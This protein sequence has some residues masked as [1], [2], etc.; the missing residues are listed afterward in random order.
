M[1]KTHTLALVAMLS[2][3]ALG[4]CNNFLT[5][6]KL[7]NNPNKS[8]AATADQLF[9]G[10]QVA[11]MGQFE[12]YPMNLLP[13]WDQQIAGVNRQWRTLSNFGQGTD[14][15]TSD[16]LWNAFYGGGGLADIKRGIAAADAVGNQK[17]IGQFRVLEA[18]YMGTAADLWGDVPFDSAGNPFPTFDSQAAVYAH[19]QLL[20]DSAITDLGAGG[21]GAGVDFYFSGDFSK[22]IAVAHTLKA[23]YY[24]HTAELPNLAY[25][26]AILQLVISEAAQGVADPSGSLQTVHT[27]NTFEQNLFYQ[28][29]VGSRKGDVEPS[30]IHI[31]LAKQFNDQV[32][33]A[34]LYSRNSAGQY[35]GSS[36]GQSAGSLVSNFAIA[37]DY[38][39]PLVTYSENILLDAEAR[40]RRGDTGAGGAAAADLATER[41]TLGETG[42][43]T[44]PTGANA[45]LVAILDEKYL[46]NFLNPE[47]YFDYLRT[48]V[49]NVP[50]PV[51]HDSN[52]PYVPA[53]FQY[54]YTESTTNTANIPS[55]AGLYSNANWPKHAADPS[56][57]TCFGQAGRPENTAGTSLHH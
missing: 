37:P 9:I 49:P 23:R 43:P 14:N 28:F 12:P 40:Y 33:L 25:D 24:M 48:C 45:L 20:L 10:V 15:L 46:Q 41:A 29:L 26:D 17:E 51:L 4:A 19:V 32:L 55:E 54:G 16:G 1:K 27:T 11:V 13:L 2:A 36:A 42:A 5:G 38:A 6:D 31:N 30:A 47:A 56:G 34:T 35:L 44:L 53:R 52:F 7:T 21:E 18:L 22:W 3:L 39:M 8:T 50:L 57:A